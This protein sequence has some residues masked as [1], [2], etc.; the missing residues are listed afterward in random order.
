MGFT[1]KQQEVVDHRSGSLLVSAAAGSGKTSTLVAH[2]VERIREGGDLGRLIIVTY[3]RPA[4]AEMRERIRTALE[5][6]LEREPENRHIRHQLAIL[7]QA[8][9]STIDSFCN[10]LV[11]SYFQMIEGLTPDI[12]IAEDAEIMLLSQDVM[13][14]VLETASGMPAKNEEN[15]FH[16]LAIFK[17]GVTL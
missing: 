5:K 1:P 11:R 13:E 14:T 2:V 16:D 3:T 17:Q 6:V 15:G 7:G 10:R 12:R 9:I 4:A 8:R